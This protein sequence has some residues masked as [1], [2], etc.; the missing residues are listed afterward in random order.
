MSKTKHLDTALSILKGSPAA[1]RA[2]RKVQVELTLYVDRDAGHYTI[3]SNGKPLVAHMPIADSDPEM[4]LKARAHAIK[5]MG[6][7]VS[8]TIIEL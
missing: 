5:G 3:T 1:K 7:T 8:T 4:A 6:R 2:P